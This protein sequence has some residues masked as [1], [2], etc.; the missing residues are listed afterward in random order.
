MDERSTSE[1]ISAF[2]AFLRDAEQRYNMSIAV[3]DETNDQ[4][5]DILHAVE[6]GDYDTAR[7]ADLVQTLRD[8][9]RRR[10]VAKDT[11]ALCDPIVEWIH[12][13]KTVIKSLE[14][15]LGDVRKIERDLDGRTYKQRTSI[16]EGLR[17]MLSVS[18]EEGDAP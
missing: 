9:R 16:M 6:F 18:A 1:A 11:V 14:Q 8:V 10:R 3:Q 4:T 17:P 2:L 12:R 15:L 13:N 7:T 5:Q